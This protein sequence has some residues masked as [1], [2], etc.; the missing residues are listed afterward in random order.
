MT[1]KLTL[2]HIL[3][4]TRPVRW[5][6]SLI[7]L[8]AIAG[9]APVFSMSRSVPLRTVVLHDATGA[10][11]GSWILS[12]ARAEYENIIL[13]LYNA[14]NNQDPIQLFIP[15][16]EATGIG[17][18]QEKYPVLFVLNKIKNMGNKPFHIYYNPEGTPQ[19][20]YAIGKLVI[21]PE[22]TA[23]EPP[24]GIKNIQTLLGE[25]QEAE[26]FLTLLFKY[27]LDADKF[28]ATISNFEH[29][30]KK[31][32]L[33]SEEYEV[34]LA[35]IVG[36][37]SKESFSAWQQMWSVRNWEFKGRQD[38]SPLPRALIRIPGEKN[39][40]IRTTDVEKINRYLIEFFDR[41]FGA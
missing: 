29:A 30:A 7:L 4:E 14:W 23:G 12:E 26:T 22:E 6:S 24:E 37:L 17:S 33:K 19:L 18:S 3:C 39:K 20:T 8:F 21:T 34:D 41:K 5:I 27:M 31:A 36:A 25:I 13:T 11:K 32:G 35:P 16:G 15:I 1:C 38:Y 2:W 10:S 40:I 28:Y 9:S